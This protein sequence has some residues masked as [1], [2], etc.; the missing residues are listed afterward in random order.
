MSGYQYKVV[1]LD[2][3]LQVP[4]VL[5]DPSDLRAD[6]QVPQAQQGLRDPQVLVPLEPQDHKVQQAPP[7]LKVPQVPLVQTEQQVPE[8]LL[9]LLVPLAHKVLQ[10][11]KE[12]PVLKEPLVLC[13]QQTIRYNKLAANLYFT[14][15]LLLLRQWIQLEILFNSVTLLRLVHHKSS[16]VGFIDVRCKR[17]S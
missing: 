16:P 8:V 5:E 1:T 2:S 11:F 14:I 4:L 7:Q 9:D 13:L 10:A 12:Q 3:A 6:Q 17:P 15:T